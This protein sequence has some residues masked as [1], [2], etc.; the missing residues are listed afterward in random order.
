MKKRILLSMTLI[1]SITLVMAQTDFPYPEL[2][3]RDSVELLTVH[4]GRLITLKKDKKKNVFLSVNNKTDTLKIDFPFTYWEIIPVHY[5]I[6]NNIF[7]RFSYYNS[8]SQ[9]IGSI[10]KLNLDTKLF[11]KLDKDT[12]TGVYFIINN[13][14]IFSKSTDD[15][16]YDVY[17]YNMQ[18]MKTDSLFN[19]GYEVGLTSRFLLNHKALISY[20]ESGVIEDFALFDFNTKQMTYPV[21]QLEGF[22]YSDKA[23]IDTYFRDITEK[24]YNMG[25]FWV[26]EKFNV[27]QPTLLPYYKSFASYNLNDTVFPF[28]YRSSYIERNPLNNYVQ[29]ACKFSLFF[30]KALYDIYHNTLLEKTVIGTFDEWELNKLRNMVFAKH[31]YQFKSEYLQA[32]FNLFDFYSN[33]P[34]KND[35]NTL[36]TPEDKKNLNLIQQI[37]NKKKNDK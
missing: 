11:T 30:D 32:F 6:E 10:Y 22:S 7:I 1:T 36:L 17:S 20:W 29:V 8:K 16:V 37:E 2:I 19:G 28:C 4:D 23:D 18:T 35:V 9:L 3:S 15:N 12:G 13:C 24:Y 21:E 25:L 33:I 5:N 27:I 31:G 34:K 14:V 26:D